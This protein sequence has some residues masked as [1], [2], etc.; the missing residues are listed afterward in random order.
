MQYLPY[1]AW[2][3][4]S[5]KLEITASKSDLYMHGLRIL[6]AYS[7]KLRMLAEHCESGKG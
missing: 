4:V 3:M 6:E 2:A 7:L 5:Q 1:I